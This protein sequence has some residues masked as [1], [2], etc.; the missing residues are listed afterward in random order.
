MTEDDTWA[1]VKDRFPIG[2]AANVVVERWMP[3]GMLVRL[4][5]FPNISA[6]IDA[7]GYRPTGRDVID[8]SK[9]AAEGACI[10]AV[11]A[12]HVDRRQQVQLRVGPPFWEDHA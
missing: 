9:W 10:A 7:I 4:P 11:V 5:G 6:I 1:E 8:H 2:S 12:D 3:F